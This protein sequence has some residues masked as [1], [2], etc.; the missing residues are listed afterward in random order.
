MGKEIYKKFA[1]KAVDLKGTVSAEHGIGKL[2]RE[3]LE[4]LYGEEGIEQMRE[5][6]KIFDPDGLLNAG[7]V[8][9]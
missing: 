6:K 3:F 4:I 5:V 7:N 2:K 8:F 1:Q 9:E